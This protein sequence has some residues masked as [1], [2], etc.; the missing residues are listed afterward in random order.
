M[1]LRVGDH[2]PA[3]T[4]RSQYG[5]SV[6]LESLRGRTAVLVFYPWA[7][8]DI[9]TSELAEL[10]DAADE[11]ATADA[12][13][14][15]ISCD[16]MFS[17]RAYADARQLPFE[18]L[19]DHWPHGDVARAFGVFDDEAGCATRGSF[20]L[21]TGGRLAWSVVQ[22]IGEARDVGAL[23]SAVRALS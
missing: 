23:L 21:D 5:E 12:R 14:L 20:V 18:L 16:A 22:G 1:T 10:K 17:L 15:A 7:F 11:F 9:C 2:A 19:S 3:F 4:A 13:V 6:D 8:S